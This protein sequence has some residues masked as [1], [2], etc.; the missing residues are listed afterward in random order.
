[1]NQSDPSHTYAS[2]IPHRVIPQDVLD[3]MHKTHPIE[4]AA[5]E[6]LIRRGV[7]SLENKGGDQ[8]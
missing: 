2:P 1:M 6:I 8:K 7:W 3:S 4:G 5:A